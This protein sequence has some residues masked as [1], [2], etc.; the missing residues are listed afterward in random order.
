MSSLSVL[1]IRSRSPSSRLRAAIAAAGPSI[2]SR[3]CRR[4]SSVTVFAAVEQAVVRDEELADA[5]DRRL[6]DEVPAGHALARLDEVARREDAQR[7]AH[8]G[9]RHAE[10]GRELGLAGQAVARRE[11][12]A[13]DHVQE[14]VGDLLVRLADPLDL[15]D[16]GQYAMFSGRPPSTPFRSARRAQ[17]HRVVDE[18]AV[19]E[20]DRGHAGRLGLAECAVDLAR[21]GELALVRGERGG[22]DRQL[23]RVQDDLALKAQAA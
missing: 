4:C 15:H 23:A 5:A 7:L 13:V 10:V 8:G 9:A 2:I 12:A 6:D 1:R 19:G 3:A 21:P 22:R 16:T 11:L 17:R 18:G 20:L 14:L